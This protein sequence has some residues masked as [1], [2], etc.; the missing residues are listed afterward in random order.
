MPGASSVAASPRRAGVRA[1]AARRVTARGR[2]RSR[3][4]AGR[5]ACARRRGPMGRRRSGQRDRR[6]RRRA[7]DGDRTR[8][9][10]GVD[11]APAAPQPALGGRL[12]GGADRDELIAAED[13]ALERL[14][15]QPAV[16]EARGPWQA[17]EREHGRDGGA[18][19]EKGIAGVKGMN[20][21]EA[22]A[23]Q[24]ARRAAGASGDPAARGV[25]VARWTG[26][27]GGRS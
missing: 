23:T 13:R 3:R 21:V 18:D 24:R 6:R 25:V 7:A 1:R 11:H 16:G 8:V 26:G 12:R 2:E 27:D 19:S 5:R 22:L 4:A 15:P 9:G 14:E 17:D 10:P 20:D